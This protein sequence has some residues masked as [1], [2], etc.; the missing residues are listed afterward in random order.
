MMRWSV[1]SRYVVPSASSPLSSALPAVLPVPALCGAHGVIALLTHNMAQAASRRRERSSQ[2]LLFQCGVRKMFGDFPPLWQPGAC[3][4]EMVPP[5]EEEAELFPTTVSVPS[6]YRG[7][8][9]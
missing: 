2:Q 3:A 1:V 6:L 9:L 7:R 8:G 4:G 5:R